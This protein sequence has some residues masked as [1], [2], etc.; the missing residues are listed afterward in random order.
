MSEVKMVGRGVDTLVLNVCYAD[1][2][3]QPM[4]QE[5]ADDLQNELN[6]LKSAARL[7]ESPVLSRWTFKGI[8][9]FMQEKG[10][11]G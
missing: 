1:K 2:Q 6:L 4:K 11:R 7:N 10:A 9:L 8:N 3:F 5:L